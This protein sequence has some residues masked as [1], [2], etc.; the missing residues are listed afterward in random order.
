M[1]PAHGKEIDVGSALKRW[2]KMNL[3]QTVLDLTQQAQDMVKNKED[4]RQRRKA[5]VN[6]TKR[7]RAEMTEVPDQLLLKF[8]SLVQSC[9]V[10][11]F[12]TLLL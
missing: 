12:S 11:L 3:T 9:V 10:E 4:A 7:F 6:E 5:L 1:E 8:S 2:E